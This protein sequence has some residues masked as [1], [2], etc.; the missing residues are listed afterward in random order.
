MPLEDRHD[1]LLVQ[2]EDFAA[3]VRKLTA[4]VLD[5]DD[6]AELDELERQ[7]D[8]LLEEF[9]HDRVSLIDARSAAL[10]MRPPS[11]IRAYAQVLHKKAALE[12]ARGKPAAADALALRALELQLEA[13]AL[14][15]NVEQIDHSEIAALLERTPTPVLGPRHRQMLDLL[16]ARLPNVAPSRPRSE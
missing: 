12:H 14:E 16:L 1:W 15:P 7:A 10:I 13:A 8:E 9:E 6:P 4:Q 11:R 3:A 5:V 2:I